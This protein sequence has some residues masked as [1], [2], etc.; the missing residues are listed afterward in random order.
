MTV[1]SNGNVYVAGDT[2]STSGIA[3]NGTHQTA[4]G[5]GIDD[6]LLAKFDSNGQR[7]WCTYYGGTQHDIAQ[8][9]VEDK[10]GNVIIA[11]H[12]ESTLAIATSGAYAT[13]YNFLYDAF[14]A[15]FTSSGTLIW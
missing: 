1:A 9:V 14:V 13:T 3:T 12:T 11:G 6:V 7:L 10:N 15:K 2:F 5:G 4:Y 8:A